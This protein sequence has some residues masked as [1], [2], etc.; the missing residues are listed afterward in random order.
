MNNK[1][2]VRAV[3]RNVK[4][5][6]ASIINGLLVE[7]KS[8]Y[9]DAYLDL[10]SEIEIPERSLSNPALY[11][12]AFNAKI[13]I[14]PFVTEEGL[15]LSVDGPTTDTFDWVGI[16]PIYMASVGIAGIYYELPEELFLSLA[17]DR[18]IPREI[19]ESTIELFMFTEDVIGANFFLIAEK[20]A[21]EINKY[22][23]VNNSLVV[24]PFSDGP[25][26]DVLAEGNK[27]LKKV[28]NSEKVSNLLNSKLKGYST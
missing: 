1:E 4:S 20:D 11:L 12:D 28:F 18:R 21:L 6:A 3:T 17:E 15:E 22:V 26:V 7:G 24:Y 8:L 27:R 25:G 10:F 13:E 9:R 2:G 23:P 5:A 19:I 14:Y 16:T